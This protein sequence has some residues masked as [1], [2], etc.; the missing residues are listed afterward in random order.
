MGEKYET[1]ILM[2]KK[3]AKI[4]IEKRQIICAKKQEEVKIMTY[5]SG[6][7]VLFS[8]SSA[9]LFVNTFSVCQSG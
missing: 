6:V 5:K 9:S 3:E 4:T 2:K 7:F 8:V 1:R